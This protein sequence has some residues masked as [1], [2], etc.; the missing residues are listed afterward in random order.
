MSEDL[1]FPY[2]I[3]LLGTLILLFWWLIDDFKFTIRYWY[4]VIPTLVIVWLVIPLGWVMIPVG[5]YWI[6]ECLL[7]KIIKRIKR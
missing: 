3:S 2:G 4:L 5:L 1:I 6:F 7:N